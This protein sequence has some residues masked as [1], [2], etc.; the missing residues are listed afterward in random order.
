M[1]QL[2]SKE[3]TTIKSQWQLCKHNK[4][5]NKQNSQCPKITIITVANVLSEEK[6]EKIFFHD[7]SGFPYETIH[8]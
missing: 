6:K 8:S 7:L 4:N 3:W 1:T 2:F 5:K